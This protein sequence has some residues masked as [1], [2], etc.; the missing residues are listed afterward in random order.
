LLPLRSRASASVCPCDTARPAYGAPI[1]RAVPTDVSRR[2]DVRG[3]RP[4]LSSSDWICWSRQNNASATLL[5]SRRRHVEHA[6]IA[7]SDATQHGPMPTAPVPRPS[8][9]LQELALRTTLG[10]AHAATRSGAVARLGTASSGSHVKCVCIAERSV[11]TWLLHHHRVIEHRNGQ[12][13]A[14]YRHQRSPRGAYQ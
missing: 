9:L 4:G 3:L 14:D 1:M 7:E 13:H 11:A 2:S 6:V 10:A 12:S 8:R 5:R